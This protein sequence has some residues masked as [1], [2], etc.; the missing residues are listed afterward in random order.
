MYPGGGG[1]PWYGPGVY[2]TMDTPLLDPRALKNVRVQDVIV[3]L[4]RQRGEGRGLGSVLCQQGARRGGR[5]RRTKPYQNAFG[6]IQ[7]DVADPIAKRV[8]RRN[9]S[10]AQVKEGVLREV[11]GWVSRNVPDHVV[12]GLTVPKNCS[13]W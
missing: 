13:V 4:E 5:A 10:Y 1:I 8:I 12:H 11:N 9:L 2:N 3:H 7:K 6:A